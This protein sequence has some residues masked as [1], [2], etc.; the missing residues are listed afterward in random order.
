MK[1]FQFFQRTYSTYKAEHERAAKFEQIIR[2]SLIVQDLLAAEGSNSHSCWKSM[3][4]LLCFTEFLLLTPCYRLSFKIPF[5]KNLFLRVSVLFHCY[6]NLSIENK[7][8]IYPGEICER[9]NIH[10]EIPSETVLK[11]L[12]FA[13]TL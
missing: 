12:M 9:I 10:L 6:I 3:D 7:F 4:I 11:L 5:V 1:I 13:V 2:P 8:D